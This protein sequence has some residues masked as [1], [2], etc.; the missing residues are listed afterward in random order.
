[1]ELSIFDGIDHLVM[2]VVAIVRYAL[3][4]LLLLF[5]HLAQL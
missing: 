2:E 5:Y 1:M 3:F 4:A